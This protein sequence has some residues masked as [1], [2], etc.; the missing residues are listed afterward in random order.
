MQE[1]ETMDP[2]KR[3]HRYI[4]DAIAMEAGL[5]PALKDM[6]DEATTDEDRQMFLDH[7]DVTQRQHDRLVA[8]LKEMGDEPSYVKGVVNKLG[9]MGSELVNVVREKE[10]KAVRNLI[11]AYG[12]EHVE[13]A[14]YIA[15]ETAANAIGDTK[16]ADLARDIRA[17]E[18]AMIR[19]LHG[20]LQVL[21]AVAMEPVAA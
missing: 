16:T 3:L 20:R 15:L 13:V 9:I 2:M 1:G 10:E 8:R 5:L 7:R 18:E 4:D 21:P 12:A 17:E 14:S 6:A 11:T 19:R